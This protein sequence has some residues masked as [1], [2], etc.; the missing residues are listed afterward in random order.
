MLQ[1]QFNLLLSISIDTN[2]CKLLI[3][4]ANVS[5]FIGVDLCWILSGTV[6]F[7]QLESG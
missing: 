3:K 1:L 4:Q 7:T 6:D 2:S 5:I